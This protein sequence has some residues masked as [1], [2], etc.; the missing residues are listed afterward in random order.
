MPEPSSDHTTVSMR[1]CNLSPHH[2]DFAGFFITFG[3]HLSLGPVNKSNTFAE[4]EVC[5]FLCS[6]SFNSYEGSIG[7]LIPQTSL[8]AKDDAFCVQ[9]KMK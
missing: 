3:Y 5:F 8:V 9:A 7:L 2:S 6:Y 1:S 4:V